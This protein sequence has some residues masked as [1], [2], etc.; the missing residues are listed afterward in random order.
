[1][2]RRRTSGK[3]G[4]LRLQA[5]DKHD[6]AARLLDLRGRGLREGVCRDG[7]RFR[8]VSCAEDL[9]A[10]ESTFDDAA[11]EESLSVDVGPR[12]KHFQVPHVHLGGD[13]RERIAEAT[14]GKTALKRRLT[15]LEVGLEASRAGV[16]ALLP[17]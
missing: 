16:L 7:D 12:S 13:L 8:Q 9:D 15:A 6:L 10:V 2:R 17:P 5:S 14:L 4:P 1:M 11:S 3:P